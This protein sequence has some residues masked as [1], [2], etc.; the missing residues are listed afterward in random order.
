MQEENIC[1]LEVWKIYY[2]KHRPY[3]MKIDKLIFIQIKFSD[4]RRASP[5]KKVFSMFLVTTMCPL[6]RERLGDVH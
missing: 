1:I 3:K 4:K 6:A 5:I 2:Q